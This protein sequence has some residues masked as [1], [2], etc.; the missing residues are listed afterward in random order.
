MQRTPF[1]LAAALS[2]VSGSVLWAKEPQKPACAVIGFVNQVKHKEWKDARVGMGVRAMLSQAVAETGLF[3]LL[4][5]KAEIKERLEEIARNAWAS[6]KDDEPFES[7]AAELRQKGARFIASGRVFYFGK[8]RTRA[9]V[10]PAHLARDEVVIK[11]EVELYDEARGKS[12]TA[13]GSGKAKTTAASG[14][15]TYHGENLD[16]DASMVGTATK[17]AIDDAVADIVKKY[18]KKYNMR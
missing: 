5:E 12:I 1:V 6:G 10:G 3:V 7:A 15:F 17:K 8:P 11:L 9:S 4:E 18:R 13:V 2:I 14:L 16:A